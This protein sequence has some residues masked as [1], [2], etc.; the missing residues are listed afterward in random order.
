MTLNE[1][2]PWGRSF[3]EY[4]AM[5]A[6]NENDLQ[7]SILGCG[8]GPSSF[9]AEMTRRC[10][11]VTSV[12]PVYRFGAEEIAQRIRETAETVLHQVETN[13]ENFVWENIPS[14]EALETIRMAAMR[15]FL[16]DY[17]KGRKEKRYIEASLPDLPFEDNRFDLV[18]C[19]HFLFLYSVH[20][21]LDFHLNSVLEMCRVGNEVR[22]FPLVDLKNSRSVHLEPLTETLQRQGFACEIEPVAYEFQKGGNEMLKIIKPPLDGYFFTL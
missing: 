21:D 12:D 19:S 2:V 10:K 18:L 16:D 1:I 5:F 9:N 4:R 20:L 14:I 22:I 11:R 13:S 17:E 8:D 6:L 3:D 7:H 15:D